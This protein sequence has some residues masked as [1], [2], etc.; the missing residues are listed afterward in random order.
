MIEKTVEKI[1]SSCSWFDI[2]QTE[3]IT[4]P[5]EFKNNNLYTIKENRNTGIG[6]RLNKNGKT[7]FSYTNNADDF[8]RIH[9]K[10][11]EIS[12]FGEEESLLLPH[13]GATYPELHRVISPEMDMDVE[14]EKGQILIDTIR[15]EFPE[16]DVD[17]T[18]SG[19]SGSSRILNSNGLDLSDSFSSYS[20]SVSLTHVDKSGSR[21]QT[22]D[23]LTFPYPTDIDRLKE[24]VLHNLAFAQ[25]SDTMH[26]GRVS[27]FVTHR[28][29]A[30]LLSILLGGL[31]AKSLY[32]QISPLEGKFNTKLLHES[33]S[34]YDNPLLENSIFSYTFDD[35]GVPASVTPLV[36]DGVL[37][38]Y[39][40][41]IKY[42]SL[43]GDDPTGNASRS[44]SSLPGAEFSNIEVTP[45]E[46]PS[47]D[48]ISSIS[49]GIVVDQL[50]GLGQSNTFTG[51]FSANLD[52]AFRIR[53]G[54]LTGRIK[55][56]MISDNIFNLMKDN[57]HFSSNRKTVGNCL[58]PAVLFESVNF[59]S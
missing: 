42:A 33:F 38:N 40:S 2:Y 54:K 41:D 49:D 44:Y 39:I 47:D 1:Q 28:A 52:L 3:S 19:G 13:P 17:A 12:F 53:N 15:A 20:A 59:S 7:G 5:I 35:E 16:A 31:T 18:I 14:V 50:I 27:V 56:C 45:G 48:I 57:V 34:M 51:D 9:T 58:L 21:I 10:A 32:K 36:E 55:D 6:L 22:Y 43:L 30:A 4:T 24:K 29:F 37:R 26:S 23:Y 25:H 11:E 46:I 8:D